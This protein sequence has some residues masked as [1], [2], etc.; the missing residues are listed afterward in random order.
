MKKLEITHWGNHDVRVSSNF[1]HD[2][3]H[4]AYVA[5][6]VNIAI[7]LVDPEEIHVMVAGVATEALKILKN[8]QIAV[9][10]TEEGSL[11]S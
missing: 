11:L 8:Q 3:L 10:R 9:L 4:D 1:S 6:T 2:E 5:L 7:Q